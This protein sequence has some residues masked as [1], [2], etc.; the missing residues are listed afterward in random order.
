MKTLR[1]HRREQALSIREL[2]RMAGLAHQ[3]MVSAEAGK[4]IRLSSVRKI[5]QALGVKP[6]E[7]TEFAAIIGDGAVESPHDG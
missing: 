1:Q 5:A 6:M 7:V 3:T 4:P 2:G